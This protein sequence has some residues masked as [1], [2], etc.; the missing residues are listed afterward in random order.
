MNASELIEKV[1]NR[2]PGAV[3]G[4]FDTQLSICELSCATAD[5]VELCRWLYEP[6]GLVFAGLVVEEGASEWLLSYIFNSGLSDAWVCVIVAPPLAQKTIPSISQYV[7]AADWHE[8]EAEDFF[9]LVFEGH[10]RLGDFVLHDDLWPEGVEPMRHKFDPSGV[11]SHRKPASY[12]KPRRI[13]HEPG[14]FMMP[15]G[16]KFSGE[17]ESVHFLLET[18]GEDV[19]RLIPR[20]FYKWRAVEK[21]AEG[22]TV[23]GALL[24]AERFAATTA[25][26]H[27][28]GFCQAV[29]AVCGAIVPPRAQ[30]LRVFLS[31]LERLRHHVGAIVQICGSTALAIADSQAAILE[32]NLLRISGELTGHRYLF[33]LLTPGGLA[34]DVPD[35]SCRLALQKSQ[36]TLRTLNELEQALR[37]ASSFLDRLEEVGT[38]SLADAETY[39]LVGPVARASGLVHDLRRAM[40]YSSYSSFSFDVPSEQ[41]GDGYARLRLLFAEARQSV[42]IMEQAAAALTDGDVCVPLELRTGAALGWAEA[43]RGAALH[44]VRLGEDGRTVRYRII[45][46]SFA[47][48]HGF[49]LA[50]ENFAFQDFPIILSTFDLSV[51]ENDR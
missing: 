20:L 33:G 36:E 2:W 12:W 32:E 22:L 46:P 29:E 49:H 23:N 50:V 14:A 31:E 26:A 13:V 15:I 9:G 3:R 19:I 1:E 27:R 51:A 45:P 43:P 28:L 42:V 48:W 18:V 21:T 24:L 38:V 4:Q 30:V 44:W 34:T 40:P 17:A 37:L 39:G 5:L 16:P 7:H 35:D 6:C 41:E 47:N 8:R 25:F 11:M 10:P